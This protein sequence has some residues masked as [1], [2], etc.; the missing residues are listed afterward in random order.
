[1]HVWKIFNPVRTLI[2]KMEGDGLY[3]HKVYDEVNQ[4]QKTVFE[5][6]TQCP[7][8]LHSDDVNELK[9][10]FLSRKI[11]PIHYASVMLIPWNMGNS[12]TDEEKIIAMTF[13][14]ELAERR[15]ATDG[16]KY[17]YEE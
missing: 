3:V 7:M 16:S 4:L 17:E 1:M 8:L 15:N 10:K 6:L 5:N 13:I 14:A 2:T 11:R 12:L 9:E